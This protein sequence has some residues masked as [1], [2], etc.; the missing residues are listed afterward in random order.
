MATNG[1]IT[2]TKPKP[3]EWREDHDLLLIREMMI[4]DFF[5]HRKGNPNRGLVWDSIVENLNQIETP[6]LYLGL[7]ENYFV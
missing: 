4:S 1:K 6:I 2:N 5:L 7:D 3:M